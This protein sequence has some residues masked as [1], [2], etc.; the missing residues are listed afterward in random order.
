MT[1][2]KSRRWIALFFLMCSTQLSAATAYLGSFNFS[3]NFTIFDTT[4][5]SSFE[6][7]AGNVIYSV[8]YSPDGNW[9]YCAS[10][11]PNEIL[12]YDTTGGL[13]SFNTPPFTYFSGASM[14]RS[15]PDGTKI[16]SSGNGGFTVLSGGGTPAVIANVVVAGKNLRG[17]SIA[18]NLAQPNNDLVIFSSANTNEVIIVDRNT[19]AILSTISVGL[20]PNDVAISANNDK[21][22]VANEGSDTVTVLDLPSGTISATIN[23]DPNDEPY[24]IGASPDHRLLYVS[25][26]GKLKVFDIQ[27]FALLATYPLGA[28]DFFHTTAFSLP[29]NRAYTAIFTSGFNGVVLVTD[30]LTLGP[31]IFVPASSA[32]HPYFDITLPFNVIPQN[33]PIVPSP[34]DPPT[35]PQD[36]IG[37]RL[38]NPFGLHV[39]YLDR[40]VWN[41][42]TNPFVNAYKIYT[43]S[44]TFILN[45]EEVETRDP[46]RFQFDVPVLGKDQPATYRVSAVNQN[47]IEGPSIPITVK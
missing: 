45:L 43:S 27:T 11:G 30:T 41:A 22:Y 39:E 17:F 4:T 20:Q 2:I 34:N 23:L 15:T 25:C 46:N 31:G 3:G 14:I 44:E 28:N 36:L 12:V 5:L 10:T 16:F 8:A 18:P 9:V 19:H 7:P 21:A 40:L 33:A 35:P 24:R 1:F 47:G 42:S 29:E 38:D 37:K 32:F 26:T 13:F 6:F